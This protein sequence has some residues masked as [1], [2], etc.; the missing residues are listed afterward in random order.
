MDDELFDAEATRRVVN[1]AM[2]SAA[3]AFAGGCGANFV[4]FSPYV[5]MP[6]L[7]VAILVAIS[8]IR[9]LNHPEARVVGGQRH[10]GIV[11]AALGA[12]AAAG[13]LIL[14]IVWLLRG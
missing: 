5:V 14:R 3:L 10:V 7:A 1:R 4:P 9:T 13:G 8:A 2:I 11:L 6:F 12:L